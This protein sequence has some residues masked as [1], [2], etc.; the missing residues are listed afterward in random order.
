M[1]HHL[2]NRIAQDCLIGFIEGSDGG[3]GFCNFRDHILCRP[4]PDAPDGKGGRMDRINPA[5]GDAV[6]PDDYMSERQDWISGSMRIGGVSSRSFDKDMRRV[7]SCIDCARLH[8]D[9][10]PR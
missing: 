7:A 5:P 3:T 8:T 1:R 4:R 6:Q 10:S 9:A 2:P